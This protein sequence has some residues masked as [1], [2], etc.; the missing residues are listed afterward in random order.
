MCLHME[1][2]STATANHVTDRS[3]VKLERTQ[4]TAYSL[5]SWDLKLKA[6]KECEV[7]KFK[8]RPRYL[9]SL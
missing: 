4:C 6:Y 1:I 7:E 3:K 8:S 9:I 2:A 5:S